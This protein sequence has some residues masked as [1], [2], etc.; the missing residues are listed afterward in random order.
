MPDYKT[1]DVRYT[2]LVDRYSRYIESPVLR[3]KFLN[4]VMS[5]N[6]SDSARMKIP[7]IG[8]LPERAVLIME[9]SKVLP[10]NRP[11]P[12]GLRITSLLYRL[13]FAVYAVCFIFAVT[14]GAS[15]IY[16]LSRAI[17]GLA[18][19]TGAESVAAAPAKS[20]TAEA[21]ALARLGSEAALPLDRVWLAEEG[22]GY[23]FYSNGA[24]VLTE[25]QTAGSKRA[26]YRIRLDQLAGDARSIASA[27][28]TGFEV[29]RRPAGIVY[30]LS[31]GDL[32][33]F[34]NDYNSSLQN[35]SRALV[36]YARANRLYNYLIDRFGRTYRIVGD[37]FASNHAGNSVWSDGESLFVNLSESFIGICFEGK[38]GP[39]EAIGPDGINEAQIYA[40]RVLTAV[41]RSKY[42]IKDANC[43]TH[44][45]VSV[46]PSNGLL[47]YHTDWLSD[48]PFEAIGLT[49]KYK[50]EL[51]AVAQFGFDYDQAYIRAAGGKR[52]DG[53]DLAERTIEEAARKN[54]VKVEEE[55]RARRP[56]FQKIALRQRAL[57]RQHNERGE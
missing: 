28:A 53:L 55:R 25:F 34:A 32:L 45:L 23:E 44:G 57:D 54:G 36:E 47:G 33:P 8:S 22:E 40:A 19:S 30:H 13:R 3:L 48:F 17:S 24:R 2:K 14:A 35:Q 26:Y 20:G 7:F 9:L 41:L 29:D 49:D 1:Q 51:P 21:S 37:E 18:V 6:Q 42:S 27:A 10:P 4:S 39:G 43:V 11:A 15:V 16:G 46:N 12:V 31:E 38:S 56:L 5:I 52:W 50:S